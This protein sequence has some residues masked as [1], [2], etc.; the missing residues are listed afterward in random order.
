MRRSGAADDDAVRL[1]AERNPEAD[2]VPVA[3]AADS[4]DATEADLD[5]AVRLEKPSMTDEA[6]RSASMDA[7]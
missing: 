7:W 2:A 5:A 1:A 6:A 4:T 3:C